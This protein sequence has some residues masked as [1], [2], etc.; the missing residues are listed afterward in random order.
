MGTVYLPVSF[1]VL[2]GI[3]GPQPHIAAAG[4]MTMAWGDAFASIIGMGWERRK[5][6]ILD[7]SRSLEVSA[8]I[9]AS[10]FISISLTLGGSLVIVVGWVLS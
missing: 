2:L 1:V 10:S 9:V 6:Q 4:I 5:Y 8:A 7:R 3:F